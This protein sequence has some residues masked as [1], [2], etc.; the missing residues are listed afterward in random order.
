[1]GPG[2]QF[3][4]NERGDRILIEPIG[5]TGQAGFGLAFGASA[6]ELSATS[7]ALLR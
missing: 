4:F 3:V 7:Y 1:V 2:S 6:L 5:H